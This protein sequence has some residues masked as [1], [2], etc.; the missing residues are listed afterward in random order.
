VAQRKAAV[1]NAA[2]KARATEPKNRLRAVC[3]P[4]SKV[5]PS[6]GSLCCE[7]VCDERQSCELY[8]EDS[9]A[10]FAYHRANCGPYALFSWKS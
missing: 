3:T 2:K 1:K 6:G 9:A 10:L 7:Y 8:F 4:K 5:R